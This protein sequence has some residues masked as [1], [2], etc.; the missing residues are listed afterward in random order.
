MLNKAWDYIQP[1]VPISGWSKA[2][3]AINIIELVVAIATGIG[4]IT[5]AH[6][7]H[8]KGPYVAQAYF[9]ACLVI[10]SA[11]FMVYFAFDSIW[12][13]NIFE[14]IAF[15]IASLLLVLRVFYRITPSFTSKEGA[16]SDVTGVYLGL[17]I[18]GFVIV[19]LCQIAYFVLCFPVI[20]SF[21]WMV[22]KKVGADNALIK[23]YR[24]YQTF[25]SSLKIDFTITLSIAF[26]GFFF[27]KFEWYTLTG[28]IIGLLATF[29]GS[30]IAWFAARYENKLVLTIF[31]L[32]SMLLPIYLVYK[33]VRVLSGHA[34][35]HKSTT[36]DSL[37]SDTIITLVSMG[38]IA[39][40]V[41]AFLILVG[42]MAMLD[43]GRGL[44]EQV[45]KKNE[46][47]EPFLDNHD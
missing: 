27:I 34:E 6:V 1:K 18:A 8:Q 22:F 13:E 38:V 17:L 21:G 14:F 12:N 19:G 29:I 35:L 39:I 26:L 30:F 16:A 47:T 31:L 40:F 41:R 45:F 23:Y 36:P 33:I 9:Y 4:Y 20:R 28:F 7:D 24:V 5:F 11:I 46:N 37:K 43:F 3:L 2:F 25:V 10:G 42:V 15:I 44:R 32:W